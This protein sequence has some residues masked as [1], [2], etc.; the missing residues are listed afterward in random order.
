MLLHLGDAVN[1]DDEEAMHVAFLLRLAAAAN[2][3]SPPTP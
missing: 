3:T 2:I 1:P